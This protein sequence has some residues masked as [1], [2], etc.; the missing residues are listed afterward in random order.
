MAITA[1][2]G[3]TYSFNTVLTNFFRH[4]LEKEP[5]EQTYKEHAL[6]SMLEKEDMSRYQVNNGR[7][8]QIPIGSVGTSRTI[9]ARGSTQVTL[10]DSDT[11]TVLEYNMSHYLT[12]CVIWGTDN[13]EAMGPDHMFD[14]VQSKKN[15]VV[16]EASDK[17]DEHL[18]ATSAAT[19]G[20]SGVRLAFPT[21]GGN[22]STTYGGHAGATNTFWQSKS[23]TTGGVAS[24]V[25]LTQ[26]DSMDQQLRAEKSSQYDTIVTTYNLERIYK[27]EARNYMVLNANMGGPAKKAADL[28]IADASYNRK[29][30][31]PDNTCPAGFMYFLCSKRTK[32]AYDPKY[33]YTFGQFQDLTDRFGRVA[34]MHN[35]GCFLTTE[36]RCNGQISG[37]TES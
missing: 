19:N 5:I 9:A 36:R 35:R 33:N 4:V 24:S 30:I 16:M 6:L 17:L 29:P 21:D 25:L 1:Y 37:L 27:Q 31:V 8:L 20:I 18:W 26:M 14:F 15:D 12:G 28:G 34:L 32:W 3:P 22:S 7:L 23:I 10:T 13:I 11:K 2:Y